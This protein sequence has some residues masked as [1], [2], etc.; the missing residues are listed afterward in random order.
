MH[1]YL[2]SVG[3]IHGALQDP[4]FGLYSQFKGEVSKGVQVPPEE[5]GQDLQQGEQNSLR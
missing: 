1:N 2:T 5:E 3:R 4:S